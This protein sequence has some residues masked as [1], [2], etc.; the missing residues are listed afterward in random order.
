MRPFVPALLAVVLAQPLVALP[1]PSATGVARLIKQ[2]G[3]DRFAEREA[4]S[5]TLESMGE[6]ARVAVQKAQEAEDPEV[7]ARAR[8]LVELVLDRVRA[9][10][11]KPLQGTWR[12]ER[13]KHQGRELLKGRVLSQIQFEGRRFSWDISEK[14]LKRTII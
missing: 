1:P 5:K 12:V 10:E 8:R 2:L 3:S 13:W 6:R 11:T 9:G 7:R 4:A 14:G